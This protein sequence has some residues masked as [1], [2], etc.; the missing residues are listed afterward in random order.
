ML[1]SS[2]ATSRALDALPIEARA[3]AANSAYEVALKNG[4]FIVQAGQALP[5]IMLLTKGV[6]SVNRELKS[7]EDVV[8]C[9]VRQYQWFLGE[10]VVANH[11]PFYDCVAVGGANVIVWP[12]ASVNEA[13]EMCADLRQLISNSS[14]FVQRRMARELEVE[15][16]HTLPQRLARRLLELA[17]LSGTPS[18]ESGIK[19]QAPVSHSLL[20]SSL[21]VTRQ[22][23]HSQLR[24]WAELGWLDS[25]YRDVVLH[26]PQAL[27]TAAAHA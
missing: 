5:G 13:Y 23:I 15:R 16:S 22:R 21:G 4:E 19:L 1:N 6:I 11:V 24:E 18:N 7:G 3:L 20:A 14:I 27:R 17:E 26:Q 25:H 10:L 8:L 12:R 9:F 2:E